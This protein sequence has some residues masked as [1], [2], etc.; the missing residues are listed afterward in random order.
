MEYGMDFVEMKEIR[1]QNDPNLLAAVYGVLEEN[2][3]KA[4]DKVKENIYSFADKKERIK[5]AVDQYFDLGRDKTLLVI[6]ANDDRHTVNALIRD[7]LKSEGLL[8]QGEQLG[9]LENRDL[10]AVAM[11]KSATYEKNNVVRF[12]FS[13]K[14]LGIQRNECFRVMNINVPKNTLE[15]QSLARDNKITL[16]PQGQGGKFKMEIYRVIKYDISKG[17][18]FRWRRND[19]ELDLLNGRCFT[20]DRLDKKNIH[21]T[22]ETGHKMSFSREDVRYKHIDYAYADTA[23]SAQ[24]KTIDNSVLL[25]ESFRKNLVNQKSTYVG[26][27]R[28]R[29][30]AIIITDNKEKLTKAVSERIGENT[31]ALN[32]ISTLK[33]PLKTKINP[34]DIPMSFGLT[35]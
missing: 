24:G 9:V 20:V 27:S 14:E 7:R 2:I 11:Q 5:Q 28:A 6:P 33:R 32:K 8:S 4:F 31:L 22:D 19:K 35:L 21:I 17:D 29:N 13:K 3:V 34:I 18:R 26:L 12:S 23:F 25:L 30:K 10:R 16:N 15:L 1:R